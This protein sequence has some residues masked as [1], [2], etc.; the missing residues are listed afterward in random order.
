MDQ[1]QRFIAANTFQFGYVMQ[2]ASRQWIEKDPTGA[3]T[4]GPCNFFVEKSGTY[5]EILDKLELIEKV[6]RNGSL[7]DLD[8]AMRKCFD[9]NTASE[10]G[11]NQ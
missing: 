9:G 4:V 7:D 3:L 2:E 8:E 6:W 5:H 11:D 1:V 10:E